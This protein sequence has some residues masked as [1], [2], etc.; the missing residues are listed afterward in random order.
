MEAAAAT[1]QHAWRGFR[2]ARSGG[3]GGGAHAGGAV[4]APAAPAG[5]GAARPVGGAASG[6]CEHGQQVRP[7]CGDR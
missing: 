4:G 7:L 1:L 6:R 3:G 2:Q 5:A